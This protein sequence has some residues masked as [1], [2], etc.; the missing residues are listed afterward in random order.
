MLK[1]LRQPQKYMRYWFV[2]ITKNNKRHCINDLTYDFAKK[3]EKELFLDMSAKKSN[4]SIG[5]T[6]FYRRDLTPANQKPK[7]S[8]CFK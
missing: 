6:V 7:K 4:I 2:I 5:K 8:D 3:G 1:N